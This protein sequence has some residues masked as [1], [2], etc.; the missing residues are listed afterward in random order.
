MERTRRGVRAYLEV[1]AAEPAFARTFLIEVF[2]AGARAL[3]RRA[4]V[5]ARFVD[6]I[7]TQLEQARRDLPDLPDPPDVVLTAIV[8][9]FNEVVSDW[10]R[11]GRGERL[12]ELEPTLTRVQL[13]LLGSGA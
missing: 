1:L 3:D 7:R 5:H 9:G 6:L 10:V 13:A 4:G 12:P 2:A 11:E 8:G